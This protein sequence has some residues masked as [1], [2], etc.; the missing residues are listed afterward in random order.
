MFT[1]WQCVLDFSNKDRFSSFYIQVI[2][3]MKM[4][5]SRF[6]IFSKPCIGQE[7]FFLNMCVTTQALI[8]VAILLLILCR[9]TELSPGLQIAWRDISWQLACFSTS[10]L[11]WS[12]ALLIFSMILRRPQRW[13]V[14]TIAA[15]FLYNNQ[16]SHNS[17]EIFH[18]HV[19]KPLKHWYYWVGLL[20]TRDTLTAHLSWFGSN[21]FFNEF[22]FWNL[23]R[24]YWTLPFIS[25][26][27]LRNPQRC[28]ANIFFSFFFW[29]LKTKD[30]CCAEKNW[31]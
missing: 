31:H 12:W 25:S 1:H 18:Q 13:Q 9:I 2:K 26:T 5:P 27:I 20:L 4:V 6:F 10:T 24:W 30:F 21:F 23:L 17:K 14:K 16:T 7:K 3:W 8:L 22:P 28:E 15:V 29:M 11:L 19:C